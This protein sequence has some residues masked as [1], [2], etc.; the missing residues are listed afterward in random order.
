MLTILCYSLFTFL[1]ALATRVWHLALFRL[2]A[3]VGIGG[4]WSMGGT[5]VAEEWPEER[6][7]MGAG[8]MPTGYYF[9]MF[10]AALANYLIG[11]RRGWHVIFAL[12]GAPA[13][14]VGFIRYGVHEPARWRGRV[15][16]S[17]PM[18]T[19]RR[20]FLTLF[21]PEYRGR[22]AFNCVYLLVSNGAVDLP[23][24]VLAAH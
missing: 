14:L 13:L 19:M 8:L 16:E 1:S 17:H 6:R 20:A 11:S 12:G 15:S 10:L 21:S 3:G 4:E 18:R 23:Q 24:E 7:K 22:T 5:F 9:G 2:L